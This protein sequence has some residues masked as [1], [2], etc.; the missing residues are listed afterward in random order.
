M[1]ASTVISTHSPEVLV[2]VIGI[3]TNLSIVCLLEIPAMQIFLPDFSLGG[4]D[5]DFKYALEI[6]VM[7]EPESNI[8]LIG[9]NS[10][11]KYT[12]ASV[13]SEP[14]CEVPAGRSIIF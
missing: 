12:V 8:I 6:K 3:V 2:K 11:P 4:L 7:P 13:A 1:Y 9:L 14:K 10:D 5:I